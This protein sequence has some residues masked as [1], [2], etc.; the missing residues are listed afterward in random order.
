MRV[1]ID[2]AVQRREVT[3]VVSSKFPEDNCNG[4]RMGP[5]LTCAGVVPSQKPSWREGWRHGGRAHVWGRWIDVS[6]SYGSAALSPNVYSALVGSGE[7]R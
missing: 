7:R 4:E 3:K 5:Q 1:S 2:T 6:S